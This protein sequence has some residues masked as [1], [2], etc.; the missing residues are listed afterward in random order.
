MRKMINKVLPLLLIL[1]QSSIVVYGQKLQGNA[2]YKTVR[3]YGSAGIKTDGMSE[4][5]KSQIEAMMKARAQKTFILYFNGS[6]ANWIDSKEPNQKRKYRDIAKST[7]IEEA[8]IMNDTYLVKD[9]LVPIAWTL[10]DETKKIGPYMAKKATSTRT[11]QSVAKGKDETKIV[12]NSEEVVAW[13]T[14][15][16]PLKHGPDGYWGLPGL[17]LELDDGKMKYECISVTTKPEEEVQ[18]KMPSIGKKVSRKEYIK[19]QEEK[20]DLFLKGFSGGNP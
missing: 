18:I 17:V 20:R 11:W 9:K 14:E 10:S 7:F 2:I 16:V 8:A 3:D 15:E 13:Y 19:I 12:S 6:E 4:E 5:M 1:V